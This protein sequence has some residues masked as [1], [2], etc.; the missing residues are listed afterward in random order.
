MWSTTH[1]YT[2]GQRHLRRYFPVTGWSQGSRP[3]IPTMSG[4]V[5]EGFATFRSAGPADRGGIGLVRSRIA[6]KWS[7]IQP[8]SPL[9]SPHPVSED[10]RINRFRYKA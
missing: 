2:E 8:E 5:G 6:S 10:Q 7:A 4:V 1:P 3:A 9:P